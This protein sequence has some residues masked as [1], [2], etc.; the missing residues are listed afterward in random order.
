VTSK[1]NEKRQREF[2]PQ[3]LNEVLEMLMRS[4]TGIYS[5]KISRA[6]PST[7]RPLEL[8]QAATKRGSEKLPSST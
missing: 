8:V 2:P 5:P 1:A 3:V 7:S 4:T 6:S